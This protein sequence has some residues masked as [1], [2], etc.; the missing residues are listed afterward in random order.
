M[1]GAGR[2][3]KPLAMSFLFLFAGTL[4]ALS[5][6]ASEAGKIVLVKGDVFILG[7][8][9]KS[10][11]AD[12]LGKRG[13][14]TQK[15]S[16]FFEG[17][18]IQTKEGARVKLLFNEGGNE[19]VLGASTSLVVERAGA[20]K[21]GTELSL[22]QGNLRSSV[23]KKYSGE[24]G[25][26]FEVKTPNSVAGVRGTV[27][28]VAYDSKKNMTQVFTER[29]SVAVTNIAA[30]IKAPPILVQAGMFSEVRK[31]EAPSPPAKAPPQMIE[32]V[33]PPSGDDSASFEE[34]SNA[35]A[36]TTTASSSE[37]GGEATSPTGAPAPA[38]EA[39]KSESKKDEGPAVALAPQPADSTTKSDG[40]APASVDPGPAAAPKTMGA[41][42]TQA[43]LAPRPMDIINRQTDSQRRMLEEQRRQQLLIEGS[44]S[45]VTLKIQ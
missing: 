2:L 11:V 13:R 34:G 24:G 3:I 25:D 18:T 39:P 23:N 35:P 44:V 36:S 9:D 16:A 45:E 28:N 10:V 5:H 26:V 14:S 7:A 19:I 22:K 20:S 32:S 15:G 33:V 29:G 42:N 17:E 30:G 40:R 12:P 41:N 37:G 38:P 27:F 1:R 21:S 31:S 8:K 43:T 6:A 4:P